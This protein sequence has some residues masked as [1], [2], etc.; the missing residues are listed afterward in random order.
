M[1]KLIF[2]LGHR[3]QHGK[4]TTCDI[5]VKLLEQYGISYIRTSFAKKLKKHCAERYDLNFEQMEFDEY[6]KSK[7]AHLNGLT[8]RDVLLKEGNFARSVWGN[9]WTSTTYREILDSGAEVGLISDFRYPNEHT[10]FEETYK[11]WAI[12]NNASPY[13]VP[14]L[15]KVLAFR[16]KG[17][18]NNDGSD[19]QLPDLDPVFWD[20]TILNNIEGGSWY[21][22]VESQVTEM[23]MEN[24]N[25]YVKPEN[26]PNWKSMLL[27]HHRKLTNGV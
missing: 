17:V 23:V 2:L 21:Q 11:N 10:C 1:V 6:K 25:K 27:L 26:S 16:E 18:F 22:N 13:E 14:K 3:K 4:D 24:L 5:A 7:P 9:V 12:K 19:D 20:Q 15:V 8:V